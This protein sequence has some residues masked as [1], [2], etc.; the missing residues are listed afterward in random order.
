MERLR[1]DGIHVGADSRFDAAFKLQPVSLDDAADRR[2]GV[3][4]GAV[5]LH[6]L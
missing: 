5:R 4:I 3:K 6:G 1:T 2:A